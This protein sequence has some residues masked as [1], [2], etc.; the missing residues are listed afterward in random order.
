MPERRRSIWRGV[1][2]FGIV[3]IPVRLYTATEDRDIAFH[4]LH[5]PD[6][7]RIRYARICTDENVE[8]PFEEVVRGYE[9]EKNHYVVLEDEDFEQLPLP[10]KHTVELSSFVPAEDIDPVY[11]EKSYYLEP[12]ETGEKSCALLMRALTEKNLTALATLAIRNKE[13]LCALRAM[14]GTL[15]LETLHHP[16]EVR[17]EL[18]AP[19][20]KVKVSPQELKLASTLI[21][22]L[23][24]DFKPEDYEDHYRGA[25]LKVIRA[26][27]NGKEIVQAEAPEENAKVVDLMEAL[28]ASVEA[29]KQ[30]R[31]GTPKARTSKRPATRRLKAAS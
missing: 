19:Q 24:T 23:T 31:A 11:Y 17:V 15:M 25:L 26:K 4:Q 1:I 28:R 20:S 3:S 14:G 18:D 21:D 27:R 2:S 22:M 12:E 5:A 9:Y 7:A 6:N 13:R 8:V 10:S 30:Q 16:D 29:T